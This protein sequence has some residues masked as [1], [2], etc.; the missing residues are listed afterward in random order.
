MPLTHLVHQ[1][2]SSESGRIDLVVQK[3]TGLSRSGVRG[4][5]DHG[6][7]WLNALRCDQMATPASVGDSVEVR[8]DPARRYK[9]TKRR[10]DDRTFDL[11]FE[12]E[13]LIVVDKSAGV[14]TIP[15][16]HQEKN[17]LI[18]RVSRYLSHSRKRRSA[19]LVHR[20]DRGVSGLLV[21]GKSEAVA[22]ALMAQFKARK[23]ERL[24]L[25]I[26]SG[27]LEPDERTLES[28]LA[29]AKNLDR[30]S[31]R[32]SKNTE[33]AI[34]HYRVRERLVDATLVEVKLE[35]GRRNQ[36]RVHLAEAGYPV[37]GDPRYGK[38]G[39]GHPRWVRSRIALH[40]ETLG[41]E[42][43]VSGEAMSFRSPLPPAMA[44]FLAACGQINS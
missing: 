1:V 34:T 30:Y 20:L 3:M 42:H 40:A 8:Y 11:V 37:L 44:K 21:F 41:F 22:E 32:P 9:E 43:P 13:H 16:D 5:F 25:A 29:T 27:R 39:S 6:C 26:V 33:L 23:P 24:Y 10:W 36:I 18:D 7:V 12:D 4:L 31:A 15:T 2:E 35:T 14:L 38:S 17:T 19:F 28:H